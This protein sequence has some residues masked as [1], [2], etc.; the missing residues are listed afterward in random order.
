[1]EIKNI[2]LEQ[3][4]P[5]KYNPNI[6]PDKIMGQLKKSIQRDGFLQPLIVRESPTEPGFYEIIDGEHRWKVLSDLPDYK[7]APCLVIN[8]DDNLSKIQTINLNKLRGEFDSIKLAEVL[9]SLKKIYSDEELEEMLGYTKEEIQG[10]EEL[11][12]FDFDS[13]KKEDEVDVSEAIKDPEMSEEMNLMLNDK[14][15]III[16]AT[17]ELKDINS[18]EESLS[19]ICKEYLQKLY[20][21]K[22]ADVERRLQGLETPLKTTETEVL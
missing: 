21:E 12:T 13:F 16:T 6:V 7:E 11:L 18:R 22:W 4:K 2:S 19:D 5:N 8:K 14:Q 1:M 17:L 20:P 10:Y 9:V 15:L 3:I